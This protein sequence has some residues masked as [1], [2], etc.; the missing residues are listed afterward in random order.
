MTLDPGHALALAVPP[1]DQKAWGEPAPEDETMTE[2]TRHLKHADRLLQDIADG[3]VGK[4][5]GPRLLCVTFHC[6]NDKYD[7]D[8]ATA[9]DVIANDLY[10]DERGDWSD[11]DRATVSTY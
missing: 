2:R 11:A 3:L 8:L 9:I 7:F 1:T 5:A 6:G 4:D 10:W